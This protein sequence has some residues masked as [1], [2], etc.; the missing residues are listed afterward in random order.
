MGGIVFFKTTIY[1]AVK[2]FYLDILECSVWLEQSGICIV[3][4]GNQLIG[5]C[6]GNDADTDMLLTFFYSTRD[7][8]E[9]VA[10]KLKMSGKAKY[11]PDYDIY[12]FYANDPEGRR[13]EIQAF[14]HHL[15]P[16][17]NG[18]DLLRYR[19]SIRQFHEDEIP[20]DILNS[21]FEDCRYS[22]TSRN[23][24]S[25]YYVVI[26][27]KEILAEL[28]LTR[29]SATAPIGRAPMAIAVCSDPDKTKRVQADADIAATYLLLSIHNHNLGGC[30]ITDMDRPNVKELLSIQDSHYLCMITP[31]GYPAEVKSTP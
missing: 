23:S 1:D 12:H 8:V 31:V 26:T 17:T 13:I 22:P 5:I 14:E 16:Y 28:A 7:E 30:W 25:F 24:E 3:R 4:H 20:Q 9:K 10:A 18:S 15:K 29:E 27:N 2:K 19:R 21:I 11:N 6:H